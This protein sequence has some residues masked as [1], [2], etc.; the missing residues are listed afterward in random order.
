LHRIDVPS[1]ATSLATPSAYGTPGYFQEGNPLTGVDATIV[2]EDWTNAV[3]EELVA[4]VLAA[5]IALDKTNRAQV[6]AAI[7]S[8]IGAI[9]HGLQTIGATGWFTVPAAVIE[10]EIWAGGSGSWASLS[11]TSGGGGSGGGYA[12]KRISGL[13]VGATIAV[14]IGNGGTAGTTGTPPTAGGAS[15]F[16]SYCTATGGQLNPLNSVGSPAL[17]NLAGFGTGGD[18]DLPGSDGSAGFG[19]QGGL[20][21]NQGGV[22]GGGP[23]S[24]GFANA[25]TTGKTGYFPGGGASGAGTGPSGTTSYPGAA[26]AA[27]FCIVRW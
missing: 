18:L 6:L 24:G 11:G 15:S 8:L 16:G 27:G 5:G 20:V 19:N 23:L 12:R 22:G 25:G 2:D 4:I 21:F 10:V 3:Q 7:R 13:T 17:G 9:P 26:G 1:A 14:T